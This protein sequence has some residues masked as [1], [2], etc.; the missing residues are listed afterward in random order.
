VI[1]VLLLGTGTQG[2]SLAA[3]PIWASSVFTGVTLIAA[4]AVTGIQR[5]GRADSGRRTDD[6]AS[7]DAPPPEATARGPA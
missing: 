3:A 5:R 7:G 2:L 1:A 6:A 4:L